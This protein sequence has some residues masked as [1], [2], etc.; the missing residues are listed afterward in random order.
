MLFVSAPGLAAVADAPRRDPR[1]SHR[2]SSRS[3][4]PSRRGGTPRPT[5]SG[6]RPAGREVDDL[7]LAET[8]AAGVRGRRRRPDG[9]TTTS[10]RATGDAEGLRRKGARRDQG[11]N[12]RGPGTSR[13]SARRPRAIDASPIAGDDEPGARPGARRHPDRQLHRHATRRPVAGSRSRT[14]DRP[15]RRRHR[16]DATSPL[17]DRE[18][19]LAAR[20]AARPLSSR[21]RGSTPRRRAPRATEH[22]GPGGRRGPQPRPTVGR[23]SAVDRRGRRRNGP[24]AIP[25]CAAQSCSADPPATAAAT[26]PASA[27]APTPWILILETWSVRRSLS[28]VPDHWTEPPPAV[29]PAGEAG[30]GR[31]G[32]QSRRRPLSGGSPGGFT[33]AG[34]VVASARYLDLP[35]GREAGESPAQ[36]R[37]GD[38]RPNGVWKSG[39][40]ARGRCSTFERKGRHDATV[41]ADQPLLRSEARGFVC[42]RPS[43]SPRSRSL[44]CRALPDPPPPSARPPGWPCSSPRPP[45]SVAACNGAA[46]PAPS[47]GRP[48]RRPAGSSRPRRPAPRRRS[49]RRRSRGS[50][51]RLRSPATTAR[52]STLTEKPRQDRLADPRRDR[53]PLRDRCGRQ[54]RRQGRGHRRTSRPRPRPCRS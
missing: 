48:V 27:I 21:G 2:R 7:G 33:G 39:R 42:S 54:G 34:A 22:P 17:V 50:V 46:P 45:S 19:R 44:T 6:G 20:Q 51:P 41:R 9:L 14:V 38:H 37:Y 29:D 11:P 8:D 4:R 31:R 47:V 1:R 52:P 28:C 18:A 23:G 36:S 26:A 40:R 10:P 32:P 16:V 30:R 15:P 49:P 3:R 53:G 25:S 5:G 24:A 12:R 13:A 43:L 35:R